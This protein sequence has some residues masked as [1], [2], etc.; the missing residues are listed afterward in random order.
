M[1]ALAVVFFGWE[2]AGSSA[3]DWLRIVFALCALVGLVDLVRWAVWRVRTRA[4]R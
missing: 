2:A 3:P 4:R 1:T